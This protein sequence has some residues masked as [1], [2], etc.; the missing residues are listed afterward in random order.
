ML[1]M[2][3]LASASPATGDNFPAIPLIIVGVVAIILAIVLSVL[4]KK[5]K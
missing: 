1:Y 5:K 3:T 2:F 4:S